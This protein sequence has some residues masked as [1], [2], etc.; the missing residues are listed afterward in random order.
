MSLVVV[1]AS[2]NIARVAQSLSSEIVFVQQ[3]GSLRPE[4]L[5]D[6]VDELFSFDYQDEPV[7]RSFAERVLKPRRPA[8]VV[9]VTEHGLEPAAVMAEVLGTP[10]VPLAVVR[11]MR[12]KAGM[13]RLLAQRAPHLNVPFAAPG[14]GDTLEELFRSPYGVIAKPVSGTASSGILLLRAPAQAQA[15]AAQGHYLFEAFAPGAEFSVESF[16]ADGVH[17]IVAVAE[18]GTGAG[19]VETAHLMPPAALDASARARIEQATRELLDALGLRDGP[20]HT[21]LK[22]HEGSIK[23]IETHNRPGGDGIADLVALTTGVDWRRVSIGWPLGQR[24][25]PGAGAVA[26]A[27]NV[28]FTASPG[29]VAAIADRPAALPGADVVA[30]EVDV[31]VGD[32]V[33]ELRSSGDRVGMA[34]VTGPSPEACQQAAADLRPDSIVTTEDAAS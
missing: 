6:D 29:R 32:L 7:A 21:E 4:V 33:G 12:D 30:W 25:A 24:P 15:L 1:G 13:R 2:K 20:A 27:A 14:D 22:L 26:A 3:P 34:T 10:A 5:R 9:S 31:A 16:S 18:K 17:E 23:V 11:A 19:F 28:F 8:A